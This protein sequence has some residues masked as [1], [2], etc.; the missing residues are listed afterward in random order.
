MRVGLPGV[1]PGVGERG[2]NVAEEKHRRVG[3]SSP[4]LMTRPVP[5]LECFLVALSAQS[6]AWGTRTKVS[7]LSA[8][9]GGRPLT[10]SHRIF[11][12]PSRLFHTDRI[13]SAANGPGR[14]TGT[15]VYGKRC[16]GRCALKNDTLKVILGAL[17]GAVVV[18][19]LFGAFGGG[20]GPMGEWDG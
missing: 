7:L 3:L 5:C 16:I 18:L 14:K 15:G 17:G 4:G 8:L 12:D 9:L 2:E 11:T 1:D 6:L 19:L 13:T 20:M 10:F